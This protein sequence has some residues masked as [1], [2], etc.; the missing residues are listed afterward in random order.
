MA[1][2]VVAGSTLAYV[3]GTIVQWLDSPGSLAAI[4]G[5]ASALIVMPRVAII[6]IHQNYLFSGVTHQHF[7][8]LIDS[9]YR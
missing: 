1:R 5:S 6:S 2:P 3:T 9:L 8:L 4:A 7:C